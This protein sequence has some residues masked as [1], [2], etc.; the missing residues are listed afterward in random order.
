[1][2]IERLKAVIDESKKI[3]KGVPVG[4]YMYMLVKANDLRIREVMRMSDTATIDD[5]FIELGAAA[6]WEAKGEARGE[7][8]GEAKGKIEVAKNLKKVGFPDDKNA[9]VTGL[10]LEEIAAL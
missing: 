2:S 7:A 8:K 9:Q 4:A 6:R 5:I 3:P 10:S 1:L